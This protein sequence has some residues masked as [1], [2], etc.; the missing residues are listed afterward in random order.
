MGWAIEAVSKGLARCYAGTLLRCYAVT[1]LRRYAVTPLTV[2]SL[3]RYPV[4][5]L[6]RYTVTLL[7]CYPA[8]LLHCYTVTLLHCYTVTL[9]HCYTV[10]L[11]HLHNNN[12]NKLTSIDLHRATHNSCIMHI[13]FC[14]SN[15]ICTHL[16]PFLTSMNS[17][18]KLTFALT[19]SSTLLDQSLH[20][21][22]TFDITFGLN[23]TS[24]LHCYIVLRRWPTCSGG[25]LVPVHWVND[26][27]CRLAEREMVDSMREVVICKRE[28]DVRRKRWTIRFCF[29]K[30]NLPR[31]DRYSISLIKFYANII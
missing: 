24:M 27:W 5:P 12:N 16:T 26:A 25:F 14:I 7:P 22:L 19:D 2:T 1:P 8:T 9:L 21:Y 17:W 18:I 23:A 20:I 15:I 13:I 11:L 3:H 30:S 31:V 4:T 10:T 6:P 29:Q 28:M